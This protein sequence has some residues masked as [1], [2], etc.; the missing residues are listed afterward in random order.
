MTEIING[1]GRFT[2]L[3]E[4]MGRLNDCLVLEF[5]KHNMSWVLLCAIRLLDHENTL[6]PQNL[7]PKNG[8]ISIEFHNLTYC[9]KAMF[10]HK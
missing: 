6:T 1:M 5:R 9:V 4:T 8:R 10:R 3:I 7:E 2:I